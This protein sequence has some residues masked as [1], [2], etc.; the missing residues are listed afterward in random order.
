MNRVRQVGLVLLTAVLVGGPGLVGCT[1]PSGTSA[2]AEFQIELVEPLQEQRVM[3]RARFTG[4]ETSSLVLVM[5]RVW[6]GYTD[7]SEQVSWMRIGGSEGARVEMDPG[8]GGLHLEQTVAR[9]G[10][11]VPRSGTV[12]LEYCVQLSGRDGAVPS[13]IWHD[14]AL[15]LTR[16]LFVFP[17]AWLNQLRAPLEGSVA[18]KMLVP[19]GWA[20]Y[21][22][23]PLGPDGQTY[24]PD[25]LED[26]LDGAFALG[27]FRGYELRDDPFRARILMPSV[28]EE[29]HA[30]RRASELGHEILSVYRYLGLSPD[31]EPDTDLM[32]IFVLGSGQET[33]PAAAA[34]SDDLL[35]VRTV[36]ELPPS[37]HED[38]MRAAIRLWNGGAIR[39]AP[40]W[41]IEADSAEAWL[42][43]GWTDYIA[44]R[45]LL[46]SGKISAIEY[47]DRVRRIAH[48][49]RNDP[50]LATT[51]LAEASEQMR[52]MP[53]L[54]EFVRNKGHLGALLVD[55]RLRA[56]TDSGSDLGS[57]LRRLC[58]TENYLATGRL[59][60]WEKVAQALTEVAGIDYSQF[61]SDLVQGVGPL[62]L[63]GVPELSGPPVG[64]TRVLLTPDS[65]RLAYQWID[66]PAERAGIYLHDGPGLVPYD[67][68]YV[69]AGPL[70]QSFDLAYLEQRGCGR[71]DRPGPGA[72]SMDAYA[73]DVEA[74]R[75]QIEAEKVV[76]IGHGWGGYCALVYAMRYPERV[77]ALV[78]MS[79][80]PSFPRMA[81]AS[82]R[83]IEEQT[84]EADTEMGLR[85]RELL[86]MGI[87]THD[88]FLKLAQVW[89]E[90]GAYG[91]DLDAVRDSVHS[92]RAHY[93]R[94]AL[95]PE[96]VTLDND[97]ILPTLIARDHLLQ[98]DLMAEL[99][100][101]D[102]PALILH[103]ERDQVIARSLVE[104]LRDQIG[105][106][107]REVPE[108]GHYIH[109]DNPNAAIA[110]IIAFAQAHPR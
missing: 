64:E 44:W 70:Q 62:D 20:V 57:V 47:W 17:A 31:L 35:L 29:R 81:T 10:I 72:Y 67:W 97:E 2:P 55:Q 38:L 86:G 79:P 80:I 4:I 83:A 96:D 5:P 108:A 8:A 66:G 6:A 75:Q 36:A 90:S 32:A 37:L 3:V 82:L 100:P 34:L 40:K 25:T 101:G 11:Q 110:E 65:L 28:V 58:E 54:R 19:R 46:D 78:L 91:S 15:L 69:A 104:E 84:G 107:L 68:M 61:L 63:G 1:A 7:L 50:L 43:L 56:H 92:A 53:A 21:T 77:D 9:W 52:D 88:D 23:W 26:L 16:S 98:H 85:V 59:V 12:Q 33:Q 48:A 18:I 94:I 49:L 41:S 93:V 87:H 39:T 89:I 73:N 95:L 76:L 24:L 27:H 109:V 45:I 60:G 74:L 103:G 30:A 105:A 42:T 14:H 71:S 22:P 106:E 51:S 13:A 102:Y 99:V